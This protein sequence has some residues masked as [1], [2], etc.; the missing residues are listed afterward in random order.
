MEIESRIRDRVGTDGLGEASGGA[1]GGIDALGVPVSA[2]EIA[3]FIARLGVGSPAGGDGERVDRIGVLEGLKAAAAAA[4]A[5]DLVAFADS[6]VEDQAAR[7]VRA[8]DRGVGIASQVGLACRQSPYRGSRMLAT[9]RALLTDLPQT[10]AA[11]ARGETSEYRA[12]IVAKET[13]ILDPEDR[14]R[15]DAEV[16]PRLPGLGDRRVEAEVRGWACRL[17]PAAVVKRARKAHSERRVTCRPAPETM[18][19]LSGLL[20]VCDGVA[21]YAALDAAAKAAAAAG[22]PRS[23]GQVMADTLVARVTGTA[24]G[25]HPVEI[26][27]VM[28]DRALL[29]GGSEPVQVH[30]YG[31]VPAE[32]AR[33]WI[34]AL[35]DTD[36]DETD[37]G[38]V[39]DTDTESPD[40]ARPRARDRRR[41]RER[42]DRRD[43][44]DQRHRRGRVWLRRLYTSPDGRHLVAM[45]S[46]RRSFPT[47]LRRLI[48]YRDRV[49]ASPYCGAP[50]RHIDHI[51][52][53]RE[54]GPTSY[55]NGRGVCANCNHAKE[56]PGWTATVTDTTVTNT[57]RTNIT[58]T[59]NT[60]TD[61]GGSD[62][63]R[64]ERV[65]SLTTP[66]GHTYSSH[67][68]PAHHDSGAQMIDSVRQRPER[69][70]AG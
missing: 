31:P 3:A 15:V 65:V 4:Q 60:R 66:T 41:R 8:R 48:E 51:I 61:T 55:V 29:A 22:D 6:Q 59:D 24:A 32:V 56:A 45:E 37:S 64:R 34:L 58:R 57:T 36:D 27:L 10:F 14:R 1:L 50:I 69:S 28:T 33:R 5:R 11:L 35:L 30:G 42:R 47:L 39:A 67:P 7:G 16:G 52:P 44:R 54:G 62:T 43:R 40:E 20:P 53:A 68:P 9:A 12:G 63:D 26:Q 38:T 21:V 49:C 19:Y 13:A 70:R 46:S 23:R 2:E 18:T 25:T 17:D